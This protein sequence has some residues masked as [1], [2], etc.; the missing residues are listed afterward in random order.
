MCRSAR[1][2]VLA[3]PLGCL[4]PGTA[5]AAS[6]PPKQGL[7]AYDWGSSYTVSALLSL[8]DCARQIQNLGAGV[9]SVAMTPRYAAD[10]PGENFG[11]TAINTLTDLAKT[12]DFQ[13]LFQMPF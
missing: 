3:V 1:F 4:A 13:Q 6:T 5:A 2:A 12:P 8:L 7:G 10:Y 9:I 11:P